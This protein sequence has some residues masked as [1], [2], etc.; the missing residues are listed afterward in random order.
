MAVKLLIYLIAGLGAGVGTGLAGLSAAAVI[1]PM[2][3]TFLNVPA[4]EAVAIALASDVLASAISAYT[5]GKH[6]NLDIKNGLIMLRV[7]IHIGRQLYRLPR[8]K[9][10]NG[11]LFRFY[12]DIARR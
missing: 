12:D 2:L 4:Y 6:K 11:R 9:Q 5:Y 3:I 1:S 8:A 7:N 10:H